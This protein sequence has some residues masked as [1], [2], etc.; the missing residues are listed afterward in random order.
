MM[1]TPSEVKDLK[2]A[3][4]RETYSDG[5]TEIVTGGLFF[6]VALATGRP[7]F[8]WTFLFAILLLGPGLQRLKARYTYPRIGYAKI[9]DEDPIRMRNGVL[10]WVLGVFLATAIILAATGHITD[11]LAWR[12]AA[13]AIG[14]LLFSGGFLYLAQQSRLARHWFLAAF[15]AVTGILMVLPPIP[16]P[17]GNLRVWAMVMALVCL[18][19]GAVVLRGFVKTTPLVDERMPDDE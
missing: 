7:A 16:E 15:S 2:L 3:A 12:R 10:S 8:Y 1:S 5:L 19:V 6:I 9:Q 4:V 17:Y 11:N 13:P 18:T 14:G